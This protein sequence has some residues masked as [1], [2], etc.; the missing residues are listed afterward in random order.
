[1]VD[2]AQVR[3]ERR[4]A[5]GSE[6]DGPPDGPLRQGGRLRCPNCETVQADW[7]YKRLLRNPAYA[8]QTVDVLKCPACHHVF[9]PVGG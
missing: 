1:M 6:P 2:A 8:A 9:A 5:Y 4:P 7:R 3:S